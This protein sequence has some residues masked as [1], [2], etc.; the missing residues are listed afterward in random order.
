MPCSSFRFERQL[1]VYKN[2]S[3][4]SRQIN[5]TYKIQNKGHPLK[6]LS[7]EKTAPPSKKYTFFSLVLLLSCQHSLALLSP[8]FAPVISFLSV[9]GQYFTD[10]HQSPTRGASACAARPD[11]G[12]CTLGGMLKV[13]PLVHSDPRKSSVPYRVQLDI[14]QILWLLA[15]PL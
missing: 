3:D 9:P 1:L 15:N 2:L 10:P 6:G 7:R 5:V 14:L 8:F 12:W 11:Q 4:T 13:R